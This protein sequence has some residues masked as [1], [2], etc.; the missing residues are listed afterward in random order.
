M[1]FE[2]GL[3]VGK[4]PVPDSSQCP[5]GLNPATLLEAMQYLLEKRSGSKLNL[6]VSLPRVCFLLV[7]A[8]IHTTIPGTSPCLPTSQ[9]Y[10]SSSQDAY[11]LQ[12][13]CW[14]LPDLSDAQPGV[15][16]ITG[17][18]YMFLCETTRP[19]LPSSVT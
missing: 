18:S 19:C 1:D 11:S 6:P 17:F 8:V 16:C 15:R 4:I 3:A 7:A 13:L 5:A 10:I 2:V 14:L 9:S 12:P